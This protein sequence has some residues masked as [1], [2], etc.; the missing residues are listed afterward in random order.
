M[1]MLRGIPWLLG[2]AVAIVFGILFAGSLG[3]GT[4]FVFML[5]S[6][7]WIVPAADL[8]PPLSTAGTWL[9]QVAYL[10]LMTTSIGVVTR[11][12]SWIRKVVLAITVVVVLG[13]V[14]QLLLRF[15]GYRY[16]LQ[17]EL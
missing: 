11:T 9:L 3:S 17:I 16:V 12:P 6:T 10:S 5:Q 15:V 4:G 2:I 13:V 7:R 8:Q 14:V 1:S